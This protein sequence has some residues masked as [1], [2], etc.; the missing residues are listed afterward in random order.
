MQQILP[1][2][3]AVFQASLLNDPMQAV[4]PVAGAINFHTTPTSCTLG[5]ASSSRNCI[6][7]SMHAAVCLV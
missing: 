1:I 3:T 6:F 7:L 4:V 2:S 5:E